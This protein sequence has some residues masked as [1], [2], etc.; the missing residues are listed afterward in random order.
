MNKKPKIIGITGGIGSGKTTVAKLFSE[1]GIPLFIADDEAKKLMNNDEE[2]IAKLISLFGNEAYK[3]NT[4]NRAY[5]SE[6]VFKNKQLLE[7]LNNIVHPA[8]Q[9]KFES[10]YKKQDAPYVLYE[11]AILIEKGRTEYFDKIILV[12]ASK[13]ERIERVKKRDQISEDQIE[14]RMNNQWSDDKKEKF[15]D[16][17]IKNSILDKTKENVL[18]IHN[19]LKNN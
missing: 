11:A 14:Q 7:A 19:F 18:F 10:W 1:L 6:Q 3:N 12:T 8:V 13:Q 17:V 2:V 9:K 4:L 15:A 16:F 5:I